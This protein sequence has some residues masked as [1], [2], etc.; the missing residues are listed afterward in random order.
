[1]E[2]KPSPAQNA[3]ETVASWDEFYTRP[4]SETMREIERSVCGCDFGGSSWTTAAEALELARLLRLDSRSK[5][6]DIGSG[7]GWPGLYLAQQTGCHI[8]LTDISREGL[9]VADSRIKS[10]G[11]S[12][13][14]RT[15][16]AG[17]GELPFDPKEFDA[18]AHSDVLCCLEDKL[19]ALTECRRVIKVSGVM[20]F[21]VIHMRSGASSR[22]IEL[23]AEA[24]P[25]LIAAPAS[26]PKM[27][28]RT[29]WHIEQTKDISDN[30]TEAVSRMCL[31]YES[32]EKEL[33][34]LLG[35]GA[36]TDA[37]VSC[38][39]KLDLLNAGSVQRSLFVVTV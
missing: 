28:Q 34:T 4:A 38:R 32:R 18:I 29:G 19:E 36:Y 5:L 7:S 17:A 37:L 30:F 21:A 24:G 2:D 9:K 26:Y 15:V 39:A 12:E 22:E 27:L 35:E 10:D 31:E 6:L 14:C 25:A 33:T 3:G 20:A 1:M 13:Q 16:L 23:A 11:M 8:T